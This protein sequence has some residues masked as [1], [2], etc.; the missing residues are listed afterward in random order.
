MPIFNCILYFLTFRHIASH[1]FYGCKLL[2][3]T[4][5]ASSTPGRSAINLYLVN[6]VN[7]ISTICVSCVLFDIFFNSPDSV[8]IPCSSRYFGISAI[9]MRPS[10]GGHEPA[11]GYIYSVK[12]IGKKWLGR[13][14]KR[15]GR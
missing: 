15:F 8:S 11:I 5:Q 7:G 12:K 3:R 14:L 4:I 1:T 10:E 2:V 9:I 13:L 6:R